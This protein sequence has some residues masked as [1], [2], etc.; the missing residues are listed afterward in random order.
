[1][2]RTNATEF[3]VTGTTRLG[4]RS[5]SIFAPDSGGGSAALT[6]AAPTGLA[7]GSVSG[8]NFK[9]LN[10]DGVRQ[11]EEPVQAGVRVYADFNRN[12]YF[13]A[14]ERNAYS[15]AAG[16]YTLTGLIPGTQRIRAVAP[17]G[18]LQTAPAAGYYDAFVPAGGDVARLNFGMTRTVRISGTVFNDANGNGVRDSGE[19]G[20]ANS[21]VFLDANNDG[22]FDAGE[23]NVFTGTSGAYDFNGLPAG[24]YS[25][26]VQPRPG[27]VLTSP[28]AVYSRTLGPGGAVSS[29]N[30][31]FQFRPSILDPLLPLEPAPAPFPTPGPIPSL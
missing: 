6:T 1:M 26:R 4:F 10:G 31:G 15:N 24:T 2:V 8:V 30:F 7:T 25:V 19:A 12:G 3:T 29:L 27:V 28:T 22:D 13:D 17:G 16:E 9:D 21:R 14:G 20:L 5:P 11:A 23:P 18:Y